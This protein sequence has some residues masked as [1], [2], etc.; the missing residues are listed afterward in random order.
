MKVKNENTQEAVTDQTKLEINAGVCL[1]SSYFI[2][3]IIIFYSSSY[4]YIIIIIII[5]PL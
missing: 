3:V 4:Y 5:I 2:V 1:Y